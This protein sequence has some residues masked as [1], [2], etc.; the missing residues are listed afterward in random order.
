MRS[1]ATVATFG[2]ARRPREKLV[3]LMT[4]AEHLVETHP[5]EP[6]RRRAGAE[7]LRASGLTAAT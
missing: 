6:V 2:A 1:G 3:R 5:D 4:G 7:V